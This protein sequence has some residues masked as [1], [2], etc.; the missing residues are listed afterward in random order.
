MNQDQNINIQQ[1]IDGLPKAVQDLLYNG[2]WEEKTA[3]I[4]K[5]YSLTENQ[6]DDLQSLVLLTLIGQIKP[7]DF[8]GSILEKLNISDLLSKQLKICLREEFQQS[9]KIVF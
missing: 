4:G 2:N 7:E 5:K 9:N 1:I 8:M 3:E 6:L